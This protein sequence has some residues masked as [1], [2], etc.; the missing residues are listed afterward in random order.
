MM[1]RVF[2]SLQDKSLFVQLLFLVIFVFLGMIVFGVVG[3]G[4]AHLAYHTMDYDTASSPAGFLRITQAFGSVGGF[5]V[6]ALLFSYFHDGKWFEFL[7]VNRKPYYI[8][9]NTVLVMSVMILPLVALL[10]QWNMAIRLPE[11]MS[12]V[13]QWM[14]QMEESA[15]CIS[16]ILIGDATYRTLIVNIIVMAAL[17]AV[18]EE[19]LF[20][21]TLQNL[22]ERKI[23]SPHWAIWIT[24]VIF[25]AIHLQFYGFIPRMLLGA[26][27][28]YL[29]YWSRSLWLPI[30]AH[31][32]HNAM[33]LL[34]SFTFLRRGID[35]DDMKYTD[36]HG[37]T[38]LVVS[39]AVVVA[40]GLVFM[41][42]TQK[43][44]Q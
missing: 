8:L 38:T 42:R 5:L 44:Q 10:E 29:L 2:F 41:W 33:S 17:P 7:S 27:L 40:M 34:V 39:C 43:E 15:D 23:G 3:Q 26:Y 1:R 28:G 25:S 31:F 9:A 37:A 32:L 35:M 4:V 30:L 36:I 11:W 22:L 24:A 14:K 19:F 13:E 21:G 12:G 16:E 20:R 18:C 6:P